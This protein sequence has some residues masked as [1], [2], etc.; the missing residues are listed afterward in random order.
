MNTTKIISYADVK[1]IDKYIARTK[2]LVGGCF[3]L[4]HIGHVRFLKNAKKHADIL[5][6]ALESDEFIR[7]RKKREPLHSLTERAEIIASFEYVDVVIL[8][9]YLEN[10][11]EYGS[12]IKALSPSVIAITKGDVQK[13]IKMTHAAAVGAR[14]VEVVELIPA[15][16]SSELLKKLSED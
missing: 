13:D 9:P 4:V 15:K 8:L 7:T 5:I 16:T 10:D 14:I 6:V 1:E 11:L 3:D 12:L 2:V